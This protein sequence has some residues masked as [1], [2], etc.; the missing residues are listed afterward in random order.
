MQPCRE[1]A[2]VLDCL[3]AGI[4]VLELNGLQLRTLRAILRLW[5]FI[6][7]PVMLCGNISISY[8]FCLI[9]HC[10]KCQGHKREEW[11]QARG[12]DLLPVPSFHVVFTLPSELNQLTLHQP[13]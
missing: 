7:T 1:V 6:W 9:R 3:G 10:P 12:G 4:E 2:H 8:N 13:K 5:A 11:I